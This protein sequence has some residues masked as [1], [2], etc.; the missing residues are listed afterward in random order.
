MYNR[1]KKLQEVNSLYNMWKAGE[2]GGEVMPEDANPNLD[3]SSELN[4]LYFTLPMALNY[5]RNSYKLWESALKTYS[6]EETNFVFNPKLCLEKSFEEVQYALTKY[7][8]A[9][10]KQK[11]TEIWIA[12]CTTFVE[13]FNGDIR[14]LFDMLDND[15]NKIRNYIQ[16]QNKKKFP[17]L[18][19]TKICNYWLYVIYQYTDRKYKNMEC[20]TVA[21]DTHVVQAT[22]RLGLI[23]DEELNRNDVQLIVIDRWN[24]LLKGS[25]YKPIDIHTPLWLWSRNNFKE[26]K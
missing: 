11:Q 24:D 1:K 25:K 15:V 21:P 20:L 26:I 19:G 23:N 16:K 22:H 6:D 10:Q 17:Y 7:K 13:L 2:L 8:V 3:K 14:Q 9:L 18:S 4:Y 5:Q 12:L